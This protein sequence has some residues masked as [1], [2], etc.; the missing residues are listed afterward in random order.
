MLQSGQ[1]LVFGGFD[2]R[3]EALNDA[4]VFDAR[5]GVWSEF[6]QRG[7]HLPSARYGAAHW[8]VSAQ[9]GDA[10]WLFG[11]AGAK[12]AA[13]NDMFVLDVDADGRGGTWTR[14]SETAETPSKR[15][16][17]G[18]CVAAGCLF[19]H[20]GE[21]NIKR[22]LADLFAFDLSTR[23]WRAV[24]PAAP[25]PTMRAG[26]ILFASAASAPSPS[27]YL[28]G[29]YTGEG[30]YDALHDTLRIDAVKLDQWHAVT[31][32]GVLPAVGRPQQ[33]IR[34]AQPTDAT[35]GDYL[36]VFGGYDGAVRQPVGTLHRLTLNADG[37][38]DETKGWLDCKLWLELGDDLS[39][40]AKGSKGTFPTP[41]YGFVWGVDPK[42]LKA[43]VFGGS[44]STYLN[45]V[46]TL[47]LED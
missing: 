19:L 17:A 1:L 6:V 9:S 37:S 4:H 16:F 43:P 27:I 22:Q 12:N 11:G 10:F 32:P 18:T 44:G 5:S 46:Q 30:G 26:H 40:L 23:V 42:T 45:D 25:L 28:Y 21:V 35:K 8:L 31:L 20:G 14:V 24:V 39:A 41:R 3:K 34:I 13:L 33:C 29:G 38:L 47:S 7:E 36:F 15:Y 2:A